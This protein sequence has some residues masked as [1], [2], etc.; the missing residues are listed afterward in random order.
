MYC[1]EKK[2]KEKKKKRNC[3]FKKHREV[4]YT[5]AMERTTLTCQKE[6]LY[7]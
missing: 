4:K 5:L 3:R 6:N 7:M 1:K 2:K